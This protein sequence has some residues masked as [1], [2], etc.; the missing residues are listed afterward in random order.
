MNDAPM[1][2]PSRDWAFFFDVDGTIVDIAP[3]PSAIRLDA[4]THALLRRLSAAAA[5]ALAL[6]TGRGL[7]DIDAIFADAAF[8]VAGQHGLERRDAWGAVTRHASDRDT[9]AVARTELTD[10]V[11]RHPGLLLEDK[12]MTL[13]L[14]YRRAPGLASFVHRTM[15]AVRRRAGPGYALQQ[16]KFVVELVPNAVD[17]GSAILAFMAEAPFRGRTA[18]FIGDDLTDESGFVA[19][20]RLGGYSVKVGSGTTTARWRLESVSAVKSWL[21][22]GAAAGWPT[23]GPPDDASEHSVGGATTHHILVRR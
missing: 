9:I 21:E 2:L 3:S 12:G 11:A 14:H 10:V 17:K 23:H 13:A 8:P 7:A 22:R 5:G 4:G 18:V 20:N 15:R 16:G 6:V 1:P 19:V